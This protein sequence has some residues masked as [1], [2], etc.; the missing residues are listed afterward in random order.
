MSVFVLSFLERIG[1]GKDSNQKCW[2]F[3]PPFLILIIFTTNFIGLIILTLFT[4]VTLYIY[5]TYYLLCILSDLYIILIIIPS[6]C[7]LALSYFTIWLVFKEKP[8]FSVF[9]HLLTRIKVLFNEFLASLVPRIQ[10]L[11]SKLISKIDRQFCL[12][13]LLL[14]IA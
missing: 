6:Q 1:R 4:T 10:I 14:S 2:S 5:I 11:S 13:S 8:F 12:I 3:L 7:V 9:F